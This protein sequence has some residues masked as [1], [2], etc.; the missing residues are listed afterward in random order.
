M[1]DTRS[2]RKNGAGDVR[3]PEQVAAELLPKLRS[4]RV[5]YFPI[6][7]HSPACAA[8]IEQWILDNQ[9]TAILVEGPSSFTSRIELLTDERSKCPI[10]LF[11]NFVDKKDRL[12]AL[13]KGDQRKQSSELPRVSEDKSVEEL[14]LLAKDAELL[15][16]E[17]KQL[18]KDA[19]DLVKE[20]EQ[21]EKDAA[22]LEQDAVL[23]E[24]AAEQLDKDAER[25]RKD[26]G[27]TAKAG[28]K[29]PERAQPD[30]VS[31]EAPD[32]AELDLGPPRFAAYYPFCDYSPELVALRTG[33]KI[34]A[35]LQFIDLQYGEM[36]LHQFQSLKDR[37]DETIFVD[38]LAED[39][40]LKRSDY[41]NAL[42]RQMGCRSF[43][44]L[45]DHLFEAGRE[46]LSV[47]AFI[48]RLATY[49]AMA[50]MDYTD[51]ELERDG[52]NARE[53]CMAAAIAE[54]LAS[55]P[56][57]KIL[58]VTGGFHTVVLPDLVQKKTKR[59]EKIEFS[60][61]ELGVWLMRYSFDRLDA[62]AG[63]SAGMPSPAFYDRLWHSERDA[64]DPESREKRFQRVGADF[65]V[66]IS[67]LSRQQQLPNVI[68][69]P[70]SIAAVQMTKQLAALR[71]HPW[72]MR[73]DVL[74]GIRSCCIK[75]EVGV[76]GVVLMRLVNQV[77][78]G[79]RVGEIPPG[80]DLPPI[81]DDFYA[82]AKRFR[83]SLER[84]E[85]KEF[86]LDLYRNANHRSI[87]RFFHRLSLLEVPFV[88]FLD[89]PDFVQGRRLE[90][91]IEKWDS[92]WSP[93][94]E[95]ALIEA[96]LFG[97][98]IEEAATYKLRH[99]ITQ[100]DASAQGRS[101]SAAVT[102]LVRACRMGLHAQSKAMIPLIDIHIAEDPLVSSVV[103]ALSQLELL[104]GA[105]EPLEAFD[106]VAVPRLMTAAYRRACH[107]LHD[108][109]HCP[110][111][112]VDDFVKALQTLRE[113]LASKSESD[114]DTIFD[115]E[116]FYQ[117]MQAIVNAPAHESQSVMVGAAAGILYG[118]GRIN[119]AELIRIV[120]GFLGG[121][122]G[123][124]RKSAGI[125]RGLLTTACEIAW[126]VAD[127][128]Q[129]I[130]DQFQSWDEE[131]F[132]ELL[133]ELRL[134]FS[135]LTPNDI[136]R[137]AESVSALYDGESLGDL[138]HTDIDES[139]IQF[140]LSL[141]EKVKQVLSA[142]GF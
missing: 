100:L 111:Q 36:I 118:D 25:L 79:N 16:E 38:S 9:P 27:E 17:T 58:V 113:V 130:D 15:L 19:E 83:I 43:D 101:S 73:E 119:D 54:E 35:R 82:E 121:A 67:R 13:F 81:V 64:S 50:R 57:G 108:V 39:A 72:P 133:P 140:G 8:L 97:A 120:C 55:N 24:K 70:D 77:L 126:Q 2:E 21:L 88:Q 124:A 18:E 10:A 7:H 135:S 42:A 80:S 30:G 12:Q 37:S 127:V 31:G 75:G 98:T 85:R 14:E 49:C 99:Q 125:L 5:T 86:A 87:S 56:N 94:V 22:R 71:G 123:D 65:V 102:L 66:E 84:V 40:H 23:L 106:L 59:P 138:V 51:K 3:S 110:D 78:A 137:V 29:D 62:L 95:S 134:A 104:Q 139:E 92:M 28:E 122:I 6:R 53:A 91:I 89:G 32:Q 109:S 60:D 52:T 114:S 20:A 128:L 116:L 63:Y 48:D 47:D 11:T 41:I 76:E 105:R 34:G 46:K 142:D 136:T 115:D 68:T 129:A 96:S 74:D 4:D 132:L 112:Y 141:N 93:N 1:S 33:R 117:G 44:E 61:E 69:T 45:W 26:I 90:L 107:L 103:S 131:T